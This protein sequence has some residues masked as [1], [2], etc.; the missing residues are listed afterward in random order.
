MGRKSRE[1]NLRMV[2]WIGVEQRLTCWESWSPLIFR[3]IWTSL[4]RRTVS[5]LGKS[6]F[7]PVSAW[8]G[9]ADRRDAKQVLQAWLSVVVGF[10]V[11]FQILWE[12]NC[13]CEHHT[14]RHTQAYHE[15]HDVMFSSCKLL[16]LQWILIKWRTTIKSFFLTKKSR[17]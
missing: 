12:N 1:P 16:L 3:V 5:H 2:V 13:Y 7:L 10:C 11:W 8:L 6:L 9:W 15:Q 14:H 4:K 17:E